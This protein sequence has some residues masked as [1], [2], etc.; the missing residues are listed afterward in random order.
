MVEETAERELQHLQRT[1]QLPGLGCGG[2]APAA[3][4]QAEGHGEDQGQQAQGASHGGSAGGGGNTSLAWLQVEEGPGAEGTQWGEE[5]RRVRRVRLL[6]SSR[7]RGGMPGAPARPSAASTGEDA[8]PPRPPPAKQQQARR[9]P[10][11][12]GPSKQLRAGGVSLPSPEA[13]PLAEEQ[14]HTGE[15]DAGGNAA[16]RW[17]QDSPPLMPPLGPP[18]PPPADGSGPPSITYADAQSQQLLQRYGPQQRRQ[19]E[20]YLQQQRRRTKGGEVLRLF[21]VQEPGPL[22]REALAA[23]E[24]DVVFRGSFPGEQSKGWVLCCVCKTSQLPARCPHACRRPPLPRLCSAGRLAAG[25]GHR[26]SWAAGV[27]RHAA[28]AA[29]RTAA[30]SCRCAFLGAVCRRRAVAANII[31]HPAV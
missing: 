11:K 4:E 21:A 1:C 23:A 17:G 29:A 16:A 25:A 24:L 15:Q 5:R 14:P 30:P 18:P 28:P 7:R 2:A 8:P 3:G 31:S 26:G 19:L 22:R 27:D 20:E 10:R 13:A 6:P 12:A 9:Q